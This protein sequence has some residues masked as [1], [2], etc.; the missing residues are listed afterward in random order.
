MPAT[1]P[2][3][4]DDLRNAGVPVSDLWELVSARVQ[5]RAAIPV[6]IDWLSDADTRVRGPGR[7]GVRE[8]LVRALTV[9][10]ARPAAAPVLIDQF[11]K[12]SDP[13]GTGLGWIIG[14]A[15]SVVADDS[16]FDQL[17]ELAQDRRYGKARALDAHMAPQTRGRRLPH[18][19][20]AHYPD[21][22]LALLVSD[23]AVGAITMV[24][25]HAGSMRIAAEFDAEVVP[26]QL[27]DS[28]E[29]VVPP[30]PVGGTALSEGREMIQESAEREL[31]ISPV[32]GRVQQV[33][34][35]SAVD[36]LDRDQDGVGIQ[37]AQFQEGPVQ[38]DALSS[39][40]AQQRHLAQARMQQPPRDRLKFQAVHP[41]K[42]LP[43]RQRGRPRTRGIARAGLARRQSGGRHRSR[44]NRQRLDTARAPAQLRL[45]AL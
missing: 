16:V 11:R 15:L 28:G 43:D 42:L 13:D 31:A 29:L 7:T 6:L 32:C 14:N 40:A 23:A 36:R 39:L 24:A 25:A 22:G 30:A 41:P 10:S 8:G 5:Y 4:A 9:P 12:E 2:G 21:E 35:P 37:R 1:P 44:A 33:R 20:L 18:R 34:M 17:E 26:K 19:N 27:G 38:R 3:L 45:T